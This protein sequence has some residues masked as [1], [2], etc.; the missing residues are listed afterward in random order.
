MSICWG[1]TT[2]HDPQAMQAL[3]RLPSGIELSAIAAMKLPDLRQLFVVELE[4][5]RNVE[6]RQA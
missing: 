5:A 4:Q 3:G 6:L 1:Q 2:S